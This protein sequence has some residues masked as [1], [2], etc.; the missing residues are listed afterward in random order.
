MRLFMVIFNVGGI[1][2]AV[3]YYARNFRQAKEMFWEE[4]RDEAVQ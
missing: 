4:F 3:T 1:C 2:S